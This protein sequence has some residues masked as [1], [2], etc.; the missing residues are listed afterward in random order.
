ME[1]QRALD[2]LEKIF[3]TLPRFIVD[4][5]GFYYVEDCIWLGEFI[6]LMTMYHQT[7]RNYKKTQSSLGLKWAEEKCL[8]KFERVLVRIQERVAS[9]Q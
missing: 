5:I 7:V 2:D 6:P 3:Q 9:E 4:A 8:Q 1:E